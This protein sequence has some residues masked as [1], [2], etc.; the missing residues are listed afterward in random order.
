VRTLAAS[1][2][3]FVWLLLFPGKDGSSILPHAPDRTLLFVGGALALL[4]MVSDF[5]QYVAGYASV[6]DTLSAPR[7]RNV[8]YE[9]DYDTLAHRSQ[10]WFFWAKQILLASS[11]VVLAVMLLGA[12]TGASYLRGV[13]EIQPAGAAS[14]VRGSDCC[15]GGGSADDIAAIRRTVENYVQAGPSTFVGSG[16]GTAHEISVAGE[17]TLV[18]WPIWSIGAGCLVLVA[19]G[20]FLLMSRKATTKAIGAS[21]L[22]VGTLTGG[23]FALVKDVKVESLFKVDVDK[24]L[25]ELS[26]QLRQMEIPGPERLGFVERFVK[27]DDVHIELPTRAT[28]QAAQSD[29]VTRIAAAW[30]KGRSEGKSAVLLVIGAT[31]RLPMGRTIG[32]QFEANVGLA[33]ARAEQIKQAIL[34]KC[35]ALDA[36]CDIR[37]EQVIALVS[38]P[39]HTPPSAGSHVDP[40]EGYPEDRRVD[41]WALWTRKPLARRQ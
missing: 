13:D 12:L 19:S 18:G 25:G 10:S 20:G 11:A 27:G 6:Q 3:A 33:Q 5:L 31:D 9:Y 41:V 26:I 17:G 37:E 2:L 24:L 28:I 36:T 30:L 40:P 22:T 8:V 39:R 38:G 1:F 14:A 7:R 35:R 29:G 15:A 32:R 16:P 34:A 21:L 4:A 23:G